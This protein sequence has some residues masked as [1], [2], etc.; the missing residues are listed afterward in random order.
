MMQ[1]KAKSK[2]LDAE[3]IVQEPSEL[4]K[5]LFNMMP[6]RSRKSVKGILGRGQV[7]VNGEATTQFNDALQPGDRVQ[8][9]S[10][11]ADYAMKFTG[12]E[13]LHEDDDIIVIDKEAGLLSI[14][15]E[16]ERHV[17]AYRQLSDYV[18]SVNADNRVFIVHRLDRDTSGV[19]L[20]A[21]SKTIQKKLQND[22]NE[23]V[24]ERTYIALVEG[25]VKKG[26]TITSWL[27][28]DKTYTMRSSRKPNK[29]QKAITH[30]K[31][32]KS[33]SGM[34]LLQV[35][36]E[37]G[38]KNQIRVHMQ[39]LGHPVIG[40]KKYGSRKNIIGR[41]GLHAHVLAFKHPTTGKTLRFE[42]KIPT[43]FTR[44]V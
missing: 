38:R 13:I 5:F 14:A 17:T 25:V 16:K 28:E 8:I 43:S 37:T 10:R 3:W 42:S 24:R 41:L 12:V 32:L 34:S 4:L 29:G 27:T 23:T 19:M 35:N 1:K 7:V 11:V 18:Q 33:R 9:H 40:D 26:G 30:Y 20:F 6:S 2:E 15:S 31:V 22:W 39:N 36:L 44:K 21:K